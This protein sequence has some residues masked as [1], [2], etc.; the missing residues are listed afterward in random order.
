MHRVVGYVEDNGDGQGATW[1][2]ITR[3]HLHKS[4]LV[5]HPDV[6][7]IKSGPLAPCK[8]WIVLGN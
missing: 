8:K 1:G 3:L 2:V 6:I 5:R 4:R 7:Q